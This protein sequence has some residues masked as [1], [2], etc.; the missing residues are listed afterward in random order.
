MLKEDTVFV[1]VINLDARGGFS[2]NDVTDTSQYTSSLMPFAREFAQEGD[3]VVPI[4]GDSMSPK[5]PSGSYVLVRPVEL[6]REYLELGQTYVV[7][8]SDGRRIIKNIKRGTSSDTLLF[9]SINPDYDSSEISKS[10]IRSIFRVT[11]SVRKD[12]I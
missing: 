6:W 4:Y 10:I 7:E 8:L 11:M 1:P 12:V 9:E 5:Y 3:I 2:P